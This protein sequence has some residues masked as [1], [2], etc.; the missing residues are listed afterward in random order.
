MSDM[1]VKNVK[2]VDSLD[3]LRGIA[4]FGIMI[5]HCFTWGFGGFSPDSFMGKWGIYGVSI[6]YILSGLTLH[7]V[8]FDNMNFTPR[9]LKKFF[10]KRFFRI[11]PL[12]WLTIILTIILN[13]KMPSLPG[14]LLNLTGAFGVLKWHS[15]IGVGVWSIGN[16]L[17]FYLFF[18][19]FIFLSKKS[20]FLFFCLSAILLLIFLYFAFFKM[21]ASLSLTDNEQWKMYV[22][23]L[24][25]VF[26][27]LSGYLMGM[28]F[29]RYMFSKF[30]TISI[31]LLS[32]L[33]FILYTPVSSNL[34]AGINRIILSTLSFLICLSFYKS[35]LQVPVFI[36]KVLK[37]LGEASYS[38]Y[39]LHPIV[40]QLLYIANERLS[41][42][43]SMT[44]CVAL[45]IVIS[46]IVGYFNH[47]YFESFFV[48]LG[49]KVSQILAPDM[50]HGKVKY[51]QVK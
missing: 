19:V 30:W 26:L 8:Y 46:T 31:L 29:R 38:I 14:L 9:D 40:W 2:R 35:T 6:F 49:K 39:L 43:L 28:F 23:P 11:Y 18:P 1:N 16:E 24:N 20:K 47:K 36:D 10:L 13:Q 41:L 42:K 32:L 45:T 5:Y 21:D 4:A 22:N 3:Y 44:T 51:V 34:S 27:F 25:Q 33:V 15:Y 37:M 7:Y 48:R 50:P 17:V 12:L